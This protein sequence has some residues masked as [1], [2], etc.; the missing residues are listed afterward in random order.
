MPLR[1]YCAICTALQ[2]KWWHR[3][4]HIHAKCSSCNSMEPAWMCIDLLHHLFCRVLQVEGHGAPRQP[5]PR[6]CAPR[7]CAPRQSA[8]ETMC[9]GDNM[10]E[11][12]R[13]VDYR[14]RRQPD[15][16]TT[17]PGRHHAP[18]TIC[19]GDFMPRDNVPRRHHAPETIRPGFKIHYQYSTMWG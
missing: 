4:I 8:P 16:E 10:P 13:P 11:T 18:E 1:T 19:P 9:P 12:I 6:Q 15:P 5:A 14:P 2:E 17:C 7:Q 3:F